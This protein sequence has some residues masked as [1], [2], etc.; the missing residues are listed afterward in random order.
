MIAVHHADG[1]SCDEEAAED[2][3]SQASVG[4]MH[5]C[6]THG[7]IRQMATTVAERADVRAK[8][9]LSVI[10]TIHIAFRSLEDATFFS[11]SPPDTTPPTTPVVLRI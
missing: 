10:A 8:P 5:D 1:Q 11:A 3:D 6:S 7:T 2:A 4:P 9:V